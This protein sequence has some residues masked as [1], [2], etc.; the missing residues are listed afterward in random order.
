M[1]YNASAN[2]VV[3]ILVTKN[4]VGQGIEETIAWKALE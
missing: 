4:L 2:G 3:L 1:F